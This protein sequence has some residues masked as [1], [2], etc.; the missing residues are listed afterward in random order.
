[1]ALIVLADEDMASLDV[2]TAVISA[3]GHEVLATSSG[4]E[5]YEMTLA[6]EPD[7]VFL[8][9]A[10]EVFDGYET[11][12]RI[13]NDPDIS[14]ALPVVILADAKVDSR[15]VAQVD[16]T[17]SFPRNHLATELHE[18]LVELLGDKAVGELS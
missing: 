4:L 1:M 10:L 6:R 14:P 7:L 13:R 18:L 3:D 5:A 15:Q 16:A 8:A 17:T 2:M 11:C 12:Q 9:T